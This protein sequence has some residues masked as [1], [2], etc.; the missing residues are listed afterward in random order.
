MRRVVHGGRRVTTPAQ[1]RRFGLVTGQR[2]IGWSW[3]P[4]KPRTMR[5]QSARNGTVDAPIEIAEVSVENGPWDWV[6]PAGRQRMRSRPDAGRAHC[7]AL[8]QPALTS[9]L[10][11]R[12]SVMPAKAGIHAFTPSVLPAKAGIHAFVLSHQRLG[13]PACAYHEDANPALMGQSIGGLV[14]DQPALTSTR[15]L[16]SWP[17]V[18]GPP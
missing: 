9:T 14:V 6:G 18:S 7:Q 11:S 13:W 3:R 2:T 1:A 12:P 16:P 5:W 15:P 4:T 10:Q 17:G 8:D